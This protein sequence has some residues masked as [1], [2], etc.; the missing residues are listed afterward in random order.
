MKSVNVTGRSR[1]AAHPLGWLALCL[2]AA[3]L[4]V[5][6]ACGGSGVGSNG[7]G[8]APQGSS[9][10]T[11]T[12]FGSV[13][14]DGLAYDD[15][16]AAVWLESAD[17]RT[18]LT[19]LKLG[20][21]VSLDYDS[22]DSGSRYA[23]VARHLYVEP[24]L[25]GPV[26]AVGTATLTVLG[27][28]VTVNADASV[29][30]VTVFDTGTGS[31][32]GLAVGDAVEVHAVRVVTSGATVL[33][34]TRIERLSSLSAVAVSGTVSGLASTAQGSRFNLGSLVVTVAASTV[35]LPTGTE[36]ADGQW[37]SV[38]AAVTA[39]SVDYG[40]VQAARV[41][42]GDRTRDTDA[43]RV[44]AVGGVVDDLSSDGLQF[45][46][47]DVPVTL[48]A[49]TVISPTGATV[50]AGRYVRVTGRWGTDGRLLATTVEVW[51]ASTRA[52]LHGTLTDWDATARTFRVRD[53]LVQVDDATVLDLADCGVS[54]LADG[55]Y[56]EV[57]GTSSSSGVRATRVECE[58]DDEGARI[59]RRGSIASVDTASQ[60]FV[61]S[62]SGG[63]QV[64]VAWTSVTYFR[65]PLSAQA[66]AAG[67]PVEVEGTM[68]GSGS[69][70]VLVAT[71]I[72][73]QGSR[74]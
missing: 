18:A 11:V 62:L 14:V 12:G 45:E 36:L 28:T 26:T 9:S 43:A 64:T 31:L 8:A 46:V 25:L 67:V 15:T 69:S 7:T 34:A 23:G 51:S 50:A 2:A 33:Q 59:E 68:S 19:E 63:Q 61:L 37:V 30:P 71:R 66:L 24:T 40:T 1:R 20:Q 44:V 6:S 32:S 70:A 53:T 47:G 56:V 48:D 29:G 27:Q 16:S 65:S 60:R 10:G 52:E 55:L 5:L 17:G 54:A 35:V 57:S 21:R 38:K 22:A 42:I 3:V 4:A 74:H 41:R 58:A 72:K 73:P 49:Q 13:Y 39:L